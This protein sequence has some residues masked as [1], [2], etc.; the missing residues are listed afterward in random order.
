[1]NPASQLTVGPA[2]Q[3]AIHEATVRLAR[4]SR[5]AG[6]TPDNA[7]LRMTPRGAIELLLMA[8]LPGAALLA[9]RPQLMDAWQSVMLWWSQRLGLPLELVRTGDNTSL[10]WLVS[11]T[12]SLVPTPLTGVLTAAAVIGAFA[13]TWWMSDR[14]VPLKYLVRTLCVVQASALLFFMFTP[15]RFPYTMTGHLSAMLNAGFYLMLAMPLLLALG[16]GVLRVPLHQKLLYPVLMLAYF[17]VM[18]PHKALLHAV[19][20][21]HFSALFMPMLYLCFGA[22]LDLMVFVAL[23]AWLASTAP[24]RALSGGDRR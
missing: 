23:Y 16:W 13:S 9:V 12:G 18:L 14:Q 22:V 4:A 21:Q 20:V 17:A 11:Y 24:A 1:M 2:Q 15:D 7:S 10:E 19:V 3:A 8:V 5:S 6:A